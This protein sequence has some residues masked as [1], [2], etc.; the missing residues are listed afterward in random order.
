M[1]YLDYDLN[2]DQFLDTLQL[3]KM[4]RHLD[5]SK[6][7]SSIT[8]FFL[9]KDSTKSDANVLKMSFHQKSI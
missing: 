4:S 3:I 8:E 2:L 5:I 1:V 7:S 9:E 6:P